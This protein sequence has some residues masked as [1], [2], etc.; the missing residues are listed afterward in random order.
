MANS[1]IFPFLVL[2]ISFTLNILF[3]TCLGE[4]FFSHTAH[5]GLEKEIQIE[6]HM[7]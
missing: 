2:G 4:A 5:H 7:R 3:G 6:D 1:T